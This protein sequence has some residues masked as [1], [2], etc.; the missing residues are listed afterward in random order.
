MRSERTMR[1]IGPSRIPLP[2]LRAPRAALANYIEA[3]LPTAPRARARGG[4]AAQ[5]GCHGRSRLGQVQPQVQESLQDSLR[6]ASGKLQDS[7]R[8][9]SGKASRIASVKPRI[10]S[11]KAS[12]IASGYPPG[13]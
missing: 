11:G 2:S 6:K 7:L 4:G 10:A 3:G 5:K 12:R 13:C 1:T 8:K 9:A